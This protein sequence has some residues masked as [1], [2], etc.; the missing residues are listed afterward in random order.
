MDFLLEAIIA[1]NK[2]AKYFDPIWLEMIEN[3]GR[4]DTKFGCSRCGLFYEFTTEQQ[5]RDHMSNEHD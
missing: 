2:A 1:E 5:L 3:V 4:G